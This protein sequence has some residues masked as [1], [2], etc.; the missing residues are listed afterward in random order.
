MNATLRN[1]LYILSL[2][3]GLM[4]IFGNLNGGWWVL[5][6]SLYSLGFLGLVEIFTKEFRS[7]IHSGD[8]DQVP[9]TILWLHIPFQI[10]C[11]ATFFYGIDSGILN[12]RTAP[13]A[14]V[15]MGINTGASAI[16]AAHEFI[17]RKSRI[18]QLAGKFLLFTA[19]NFY[20]FVE[21]LR[22]HHKWVGTARDAATA[23]R[24]QSLYSFFITSATG[25]MAGAWKLERERCIKEGR[26]VLGPG[27]Y[28][29][30]QIFFHALF[31]SLLYM[32]FGGLALIAWFVHGI[33]ANFLLE[34]VN[35]I[36]HYGL[37]RSEKER[38]TEHHS[39]QT[40][41]LVSR[42]VLS[43][44]SRHADHHYYASKPFHTLDTYDKSPVL[45]GGYASL[46][47]AAMIPPL[48]KRLT[49]P[50]LDRLQRSGPL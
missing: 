37:T 41:K 30:R 29:M 28:V 25:Q 42:F 12:S 39:W 18:Y 21:H 43:D 32:V 22:V 35:Y 1:R 46:F 44:L 31:A 33:I 16:V 3:P 20:F 47:L 40:D 13:V 23:K 11:I 10:A 14:A 2:T 26:A 34:Y 15:S 36:E 38:V 9:N 5:S 50:I 45:P 19:G 4:V 17:H 27:N 8:D 24:N 6:N 48:W 7:G 49:H